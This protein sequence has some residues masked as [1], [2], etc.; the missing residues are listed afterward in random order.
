MFIAEMVGKVSQVL[1]S[2][3]SKSYIIDTA[4][5]VLHVFSMAISD[6]LF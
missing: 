5:G 6:Q 2:K 4:L 1:T 3:L